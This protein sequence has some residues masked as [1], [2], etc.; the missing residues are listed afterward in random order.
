MWAPTEGGGV[1]MW[2]ATMGGDPDVRRSFPGGVQLC[3]CVG[4]GT[5]WEEPRFG[6]LPS[7]DAQM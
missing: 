3:V 4:G 2:G 6:V 1:Q 7:E 5:Q